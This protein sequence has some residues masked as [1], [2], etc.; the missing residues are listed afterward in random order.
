MKELIT[1]RLILDHLEDKDA[2]FI[3]ALR[4]DPIVN[5]FLD[6]DPMKTLEEAMA[7]IEKIKKGYFSGETYYWVIRQEKHGP[8]IGTVCLWNF[9]PCKSIAELGYEM[10][11]SFQ[12]KGFMNETVSEVI[13]FAFEELELKKLLAFTNKKNIRSSR[14]L[15]ANNFVGPFDPSA[16]HPTDDHFYVLQK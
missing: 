9:S 6:R 16:D 1:Q 11:P 3:L 4:S 8:L 10:R 12:G 2:E 13:R 7:F 14:L 15:I 5:E